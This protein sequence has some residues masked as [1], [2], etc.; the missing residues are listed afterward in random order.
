MTTSNDDN[1]QMDAYLRETYEAH[2]KEERVIAAIKSLQMEL[3]SY[4]YL[5]KTKIEGL[6]EA[7]RTIQTKQSKE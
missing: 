3:E 1:Q 5:M 2:L 4:T 7:L 6:K